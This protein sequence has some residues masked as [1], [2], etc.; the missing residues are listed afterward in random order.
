MNNT[1]KQASSQP[2]HEVGFHSDG[3]CTNKLRKAFGA[4]V[5]T[6]DVSLSVSV[7]EIHALIGP[8]GAGKT[9]LM[10][11]LSG[12]LAPDSG[13]VFLDGQDITSLAVHTRTLRG[14]ARSFQI[15]SVFDEF[16]VKTNI[17]VA[18]AAKHRRARKALIAEKLTHVVDQV[19]LSEHLNT[20][21]AALSHG[22]K[23]L[24]DVAM[25]LASEPKYLLLDEP[26]AGVGPA[27][28]ASLSVLIDELSKTHGV[29]LVEHD[30]DVVFSI[31]D[32]VSVL[33]A[34]EIVA[35]GLPEE[36]RQNQMVKNIYLGSG[37]E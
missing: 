21:A 3:L 6:D 23:R 4:L 12:Q 16:T 31:A 32:R 29:L 15:T 34:G 20:T 27:G 28:R 30:M 7:G 25:A 19:G 17:E 5:V 11:Q 37:D 35:S 10:A 36:I 18:I 13:R 33:V 9:T 22:Q 2:S 1:A 14:L 24:L 8:N 26:M